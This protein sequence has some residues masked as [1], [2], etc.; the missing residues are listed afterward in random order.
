MRQS[1][2][3]WAVLVIALIGL[4]LFGWLGI[5][6]FIFGETRHTERDLEMVA[7]KVERSGE[8]HRGRGGAVLQIWIAGQA[9]PFQGSSISYPKCYRKD[10]LAALQPGAPVEIGILPAEKAKPYRSGLTRQ[11]FLN[12]YALAVNGEIALS[13]DDY[14]RCAAHNEGVGRIVDPVLLA[15]S[16]LLLIFSV[17]TIASRRR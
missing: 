3:A 6:L 2:N 16:L 8:V 13:I 1:N 11:P 12:I 7:G 17:R 15:V 9:V 4:G 5:R 10:L 14:N